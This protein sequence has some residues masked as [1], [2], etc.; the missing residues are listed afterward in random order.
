[1]DIDIDIYDPWV[2]KYEAE[3]EYGLTPNH[4]D[5]FT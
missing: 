3:A 4:R 5:S 1:Y 2:D